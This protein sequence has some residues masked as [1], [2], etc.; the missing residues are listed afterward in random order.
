VAI[1][2]FREQVT[3][4][5]GQTTWVPAKGTINGQE[6][7]L[8]SVYFKD[9]TYVAMDNSGNVLLVFEWTAEGSQLSEQITSRLIGKPLA[10]FEGDEPLLGEDG[11]PI[12][13]IVQ[14]V[15]KDRG[16]I[17]GL[18]LKEANALS[19]LLNASQ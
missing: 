15:I 11:Q 2:E 18:S 8:S 7:V 6:K 9:N 1:L 14:S 10:I 19:M 3:D 17:Q 16:Q 13:P 4:A 12:A 5:N